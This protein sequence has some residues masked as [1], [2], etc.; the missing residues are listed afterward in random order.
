[1]EPDEVITEADLVAYVDGRLSAERS[2]R[3]SAWLDEH[4]AEKSRVEAWRPQSDILHAALDPVLLEPVPDRLSV[5]PPRRRRRWIAPAAMAA[6]LAAGIGIGFGIWGSNG[7][8]TT[9]SIAAIAMSAHDVYIR[10]VR[11]P[12]EV[13]V[14]DEAHLVAWLSNRMDT[15]IAP[16]DLSGD[17]LSLLG[18]RVVPDDGRPAAL[19]MYENAS[20]ERY[21]LLVVRN[22]EAEITSFRYAS[23]GSSG[24]SYWLAGSIG[25]ALSG[26]ADRET[27]LRLSRIIYEQLG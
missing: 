15:E 27:L 10:E 7:P 16:P 17:G 26:P 11:H 3:V 2:A 8:V 22:A 12:I 24:T 18:G 20:G 6:S 23:A 14:S 1:M 21:T 5:L 25:Y 4:P 19:L 9:N 13:P